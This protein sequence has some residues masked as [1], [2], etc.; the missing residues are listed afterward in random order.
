MPGYTTEDIRNVAL[1]GHGGTGKTTLV[2]ALLHVAGVISSPGEVVKGTTVC[3]TDPQ[4]KQH[5][6][7]LNSSVVALEHEGRHINLIDT[8]GYPDFLGRA[9]SALPAAETAAIVIDARSGVDI[10][11]RRMMDVARQRK[12]CR[13]LVVNKID[14]PDI[15]L[16]ALMAEIRDTFG[17]E[18]L[19]VNLPA[20]GGTRVVD[21]FLAPGDATTDFSSVQEAHEQIIDQVVELDEELMELYLEQGEELAPDRLH[22]AFEEAL[23][24]GHLIPVCFVSAAAGIGVDRL[25]QVIARLM[26]N[27]MEGNP[28][29]FRDGEGKQAKPFLVKPDPSLHVV[30]HVFK[31]AIDTFTGRVGV[32]RIHQGTVTKDSQLFIGD[33]RKP[34]KV[35]HL[36]RVNGKETVETDRGIPGDICA[37]SK[38]DDIHYDAVLHDSHDEDQIYLRSIDLP[39][40]MYGLAIQASNHGDEQKLSDAL[41]KLS[42]EDPCFRVEHNAELNETVIRGL[43]D[44]HLRMTLE[45]MRDRYNVGVDTR[46]PRIAYQET[47]RAPAEGHYRH[48]KQTGGAGQFGE[49]FLRVEPLE[50][51]TGFEFVNAVVG[52][53]IPHGLI[54]AVEK[55]V[56]QVLEQGAVA[57]YPLGDV[58]VTVYDGKHHPV[59]SKEVAFVTAAKKAFIDAV[60]KA[61]PVILEPVVDIQVNVPHAN[62]G[63]VTGDLASRRGRISGTTASSGGL[64]T[65]SGQ[66]PLS[67]LGD[68]QSHLKSVTGGAGAYS[69]QLSHYDPVPANVQADLIAAYKPHAD[70]D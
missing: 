10:S 16:E 42:A 51:G 69:M 9:L 20:E 46:P 44:L 39:E 50:R 47:V 29:P 30:A 12:L 40:P 27:P 41:H 8:P 65:V 19:P 64:S 67:E 31:V 33:A 58:R 23:R 56:R 24:E 18:C 48:K 13:M 32:F 2:E 4:E 11:S 45:K 60:S 3:D 43:G 25:L 38:V 53:V 5:Q 49:V 52:G 7:S 59:D 54:P 57:G 6:H 62:L 1:V 14:S 35:S 37:V 36:L 63:D 61:K 26:P 21:C 17:V 34:F 66:V 55:G 28:P 15:D 22:D 68:Y 70:D